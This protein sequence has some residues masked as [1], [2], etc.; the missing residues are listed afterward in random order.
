MA[1][2][3][4]AHILVVDDEPDLR[5]LLCD[6]LSAPDLQ[7]SAVASGADAMEFVK[8]NRT[9]FIVTDMHLGDCT[10][11]DVIDR[12]HNQSMEIPT[13]VITGLGDVK[14]LTAA[15]QRRPVEL[16]TKPLNLAR[17]KQTIIDELDRRASATR[18]GRRASRL[19]GLAHK[20]NQDR[21]S[22]RQQL[23]GS[24][25]DLTASYRDLA[26]RMTIQ[27]A[28]LRYQNEL[29]AATSDDDVFRSLFR[30]FLSNSGPLFGVALA[31][32]ESATL[33]IAGR[34]GVPSPDN[35]TFCQTFCN[36]IV[37]S[38]L[39]TPK[40]LIFDAMERAEMFDPSIHRRLVGLNVLAVPLIPC[41]GELIGMV[42]LYRKGEQP[43]IDTDLALADMISTPTALA[44]RKNG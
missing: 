41:E 44:I 13:V 1:R 30:L 42:V 2:S 5:E 4:A 31:C 6:A 34:F 14:T 15:S 39:A 19:R 29:I 33:R 16:M 38:L 18:M 25:A 36:P 23:D 10:G 43:F 28:V 24:C 37:D 21:R 20:L 22:L 40:C 9:D 26:G 8:H 3:T 7:V 32:D 17:L 35:L 27:K 12:L 11:L